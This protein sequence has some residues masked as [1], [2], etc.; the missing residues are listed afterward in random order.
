MKF[1]EANPTVLPRDQISSTNN[2]N[3]NSNNNNSSNNN[4]SS[5]NTDELEALKKQNAQLLKEVESL[6]SDNMKVKKSRSYLKRKNA[7]LVTSVSELKSRVQELTND[8]GLTKNISEV[9][10]KC[11]SEVPAQM[12]EMTVK[13]ACGVQVQQ[14]HPAIRKFALT[15]QLASSKAYRYIFVNFN[16]LINEQI[17]IN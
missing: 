8:L 10:K 6:K 9:L 3:T 4:K 2:S 14:Y 17:W 1:A 11:T 13:R 12:F 15:L 5:N 16:P 7:N